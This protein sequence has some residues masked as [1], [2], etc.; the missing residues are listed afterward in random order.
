MED[1]L[2]ELHLSPHPI[3]YDHLLY[4]RTGPSEN[5]VTKEKM[6]YFWLQSNQISRFFNHTIAAMLEPE[7]VNKQ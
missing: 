5:D 2:A 1:G 4:Q 6:S 3:V 7:I